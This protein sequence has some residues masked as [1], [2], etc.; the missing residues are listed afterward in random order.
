MQDLF[1]R[2]IEQKRF[3]GN[4]SLESSYLQNSLFN[5]EKYQ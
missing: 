4:I 3:S 1:D 2:F 5:L